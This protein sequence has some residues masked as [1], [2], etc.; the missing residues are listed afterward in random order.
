MS[1]EPLDFAYLKDEERGLL[2][3]V[4]LLILAKFEAAISSSSEPN[5]EEKAIRFVGD[6]IASH[7]KESESFLTST[8]QVLTYVASLTPPEHYGQEVLVRVV[9]MLE[10]C[11]PWRDLPGF[12]I[13][14]RDSWNH[15]MSSSV[16]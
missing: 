15:S 7:P 4:D 11:G 13:S 1:N 10:Q 8:W 14:I 3:E 6:L 5:V 9:G 16:D 2:D 12:G